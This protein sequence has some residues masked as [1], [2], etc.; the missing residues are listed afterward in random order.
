MDPKPLRQRGAHPPTGQA[1]G[2]HQPL[3]SFS[4]PLTT[5]FP[6]PP[7]KSFLSVNHQ[8][9]TLKRDEVTS[10]L[11][12]VMSS[13][14]P[15]MLLIQASRDQTSYHTWNH[16]LLSS[17]WQRGWGSQMQLT[18][19]TFLLDAPVPYAGRH[20]LDKSLLTSCLQSSQYQLPQLLSQMRADLIALTQT[21]PIL[22][23]SVSR[24]RP[25]DKSQYH[26]EQS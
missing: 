4:M 16:R 15:A 19:P 1:E 17:R 13:P 25:R 12:N 18:L 10:S 22:Y 5:S 24:Y 20:N 26:G 11:E 6:T 21:H 14:P 8:H 2:C 3:T 23:A 7:Q 9:V